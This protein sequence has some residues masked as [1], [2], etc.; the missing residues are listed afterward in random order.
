MRGGHKPSL[1]TTPS[2]NSK[3][4]FSKEGQSNMAPQIK[5]LLAFLG[6]MANV[7]LIIG[8]HDLG[9]WIVVGELEHIRL[10]SNTATQTDSCARS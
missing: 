7:A 4:T 3:N 9:I 6:S 5:P 8:W 2:W 1:S 10:L